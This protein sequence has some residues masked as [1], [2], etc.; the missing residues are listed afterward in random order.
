MNKKKYSEKEIQEIYNRCVKEPNSLIETIED[1][2]D[3]WCKLF[4]RINEE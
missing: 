2:M 3:L 1:A 4:D